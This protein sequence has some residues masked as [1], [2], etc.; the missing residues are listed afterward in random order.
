M[1]LYVDYYVGASK[2]L[3]GTLHQTHISVHTI[4]TGADPLILKPYVVRMYKVE[5][6]SQ[7]IPRA[8]ALCRGS[9]R[10]WNVNCLLRAAIPLLCVPSDRRRYGVTVSEPSY[11]WTTSGDRPT[12]RERMLWD[13]SLQTSCG[14]Q[15]LERRIPTP[16]VLSL[17]V[18]T[19]LQFTPTSYL[20]RRLKLLH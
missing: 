6:Y 9:G 5:T 11:S 3:G 8:S 12:L 16:R 14:G 1:H 17:N 4:P 13:A 18:G 7:P 20:R 15:R 10:E 19:D 2:G